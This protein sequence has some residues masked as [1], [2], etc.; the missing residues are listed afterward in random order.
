MPFD[1]GLGRLAGPKTG[2]LRLLRDI[3]H[4]FDHLLRYRVRRDLD[5]QFLFY[6]ADVF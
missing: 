1:D 2:D 4:R 5:M 6:R 3:G